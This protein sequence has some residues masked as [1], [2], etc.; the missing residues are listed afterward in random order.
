MI[1]CSDHNTQTEWLDT[2]QDPHKYCLQETHF[3]HKDTYSLNVR[4]WRKILHSNGNP[5]K[6]RV[7]ILISGKMD[8]KL[9]KIARHKGGH[10][11]MI[12]GSI[13]DKD[14]TI[15]KNYA[16]NIVAL[17][18]M[19]QTL[20]D[21]KRGIGTNTTIIAVYITPL[22]WMGRSSELKI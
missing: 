8:L 14:I 3:R 20:T 18:Y 12:K 11:I 19:W 1:K 22:R 6:A 15:V 21:I 9:Q 16:P 10:Y 7:V 13:R 17:Q 2:K 4:W 5:K